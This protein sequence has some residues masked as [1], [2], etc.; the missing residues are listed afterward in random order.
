[1]GLSTARILQERGARVTIYSRE[2]PPHTTSNVS[3]GQ[4]WPGG[5]SG[6]DPAYHRQFQEAARRAFARF[7][8]M[9]R[10]A[11]YGVFWQD[12]WTFRPGPPPGPPNPT[13]LW[14]R[15]IVSDYQPNLEPGQ[16]PFGDRYMSYYRT[17]M[18]EPGR[19]L[20]T[21][22]QE[23][24][25]SGG[26]IEQRGFSHR[27][28]IAALP[29]PIVFNCT[30]LGSGA[31]FGDMAVLPVRGQLVVLRPQPQVTYNLQGFGGGYIFARPDGLIL[32]GSET[33]D[34]WRLE[35]DSGDTVRILAAAK[36]GMALVP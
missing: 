18:I 31:L 33:A 2:L 20:E 5:P 22:M 19:H 24:H 14:L 25:E 35:P 7:R 36:R 12:N 15:D 27:E 10:R 21:L 32:G 26:R 23:V 16:H 11:R 3:G 4:W 29:Q 28:E 8:R 30:G 6:T 34:D 13:T 9:E 1:M 17:L